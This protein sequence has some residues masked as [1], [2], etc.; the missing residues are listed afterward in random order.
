MTKE[1]IESDFLHVLMDFVHRPA[2][3]VIAPNPV[4]VDREFL[5]FLYRV[6]DLRINP[7][8]EAPK[9]KTLEEHNTL[10]AAA[11]DAMAQRSPRAN[12]IACPQCG[13]ELVDSNPSVLASNP[14]KKNTKCLSCDYV[15]YRI[16]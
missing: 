11:H 2:F 5:D 12:G 8:K 6:I 13:K 7:P 3:H 15:G 10:R 9:L 1:Q 14:P 4:G 16:A